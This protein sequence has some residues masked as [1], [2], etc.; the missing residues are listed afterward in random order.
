MIQNRKLGVPAVF[1][2]KKKLDVVINDYTFPFLRSATYNAAENFLNSR[3]TGCARPINI[4]SMLGNSLV[5][6]SGGIT[7]VCASCRLGG[8][9]VVEQQVATPSRMEEYLRHAGKL[10]DRGIPW[11]VI[12]VGLRFGNLR[13]LVERPKQFG[14]RFETLRGWWTKEGTIQELYGSTYNGLYCGECGLFS[15]T[16]GAT[17]K[18]CSFPLEHQWGFR[19]TF[20]EEI[21]LLSTPD[22]YARIDKMFS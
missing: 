13:T 1:A 8:E 19:T 11:I 9:F 18:G 20:A 4:G 12:L 15:G 6:T 10:A 17:C 3:C 14:F 5:A 21:N 22:A 16:A 2:F 7:V